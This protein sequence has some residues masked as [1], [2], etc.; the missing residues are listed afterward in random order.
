MCGEQKRMDEDSSCNTNNYIHMSKAYKL[1][2]WCNMQDYQTKP[3]FRHKQRGR[4][5]KSEELVIDIAK[6]N[7]S[8]SP[9]M[10]KKLRGKVRGMKE[11]VRKR[12]GEGQTNKKQTKQSQSDDEEDCAAEACLRPNG[13]E[14]DWVQCDGGCDQ[15]FHM[16]CVGLDKHDINEDE[17]YICIKCSQ[18]NPQNIDV[19]CFQLESPASPSEEENDC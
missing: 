18:N 7:T 16:L 10:D 12:R 9:T 6:K 11:G 13:R 4:K 3:G 8:K 1:T 2:F 19:S 15:W 17:D 14:V 5:R